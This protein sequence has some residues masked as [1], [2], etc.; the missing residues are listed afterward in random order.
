LQNTDVVFLFGRGWH[1]TRS[2]MYLAAVAARDFD[3]GPSKWFY[4]A[5]N[6]RWTT[7]ERDAAGLLGTDDVSMHHSVAWNAALG[8]FVLLRGATGRVVAQFAPAPWGPWSAP[9]TIVSPADEWVTRL[10]HRPGSDRIVQSLV[11]IY[12]RD[13]TEITL[14]DGDRGVPYGPNLLERFTENVDDGTVTLYYTL[15][16]WNPYQV[17]LVSTT[18][19]GDARK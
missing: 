3:A 2:D 7:S 5:G 17:L 4:F 19:K 10:L 16:G 6:G 13:G 12:N 1:T 14:P 11:P 8:R 18:F 15:S 9:I